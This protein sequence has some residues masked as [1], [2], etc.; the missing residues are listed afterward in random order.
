[1]IYPK[2][3]SGRRREGAHGRLVGVVV[4]PDR[5]DEREDALKDVDGHA[6]GGAVSVSF[7]VESPLEGLVDPLDDL[8]LTSMNFSFAAELIRGA[9]RAGESSARVPAAR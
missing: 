2:G 5:G 1:M 7:E 8:P 6:A 9:L 4:V 3:F